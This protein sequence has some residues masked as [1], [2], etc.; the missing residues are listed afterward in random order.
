MSGARERLQ[1]AEDGSGRSGIG[2]LSASL[3]TPIAA[4]LAIAG[5]FC[6]ANKS[7]TVWSG[8]VP[9]V[10]LYLIAIVL[11]LAVLLSERRTGDGPSAPVGLPSHLK[12]GLEWGLLAGVIVVGLFLRIHAI[13][14]IP[15]GLNNDE[16]INAIEAT[17][18]V[19]GKPFSTVTERGLNRETMFHY[20]AAFSY[21]HPRI[22]LNLVRAMPAVFG[23]QSKLI[24]DPLIDRV[25]PLR[26]VSIA[27]AYSSYRFYQGHKVVKCCG[28][29]LA[30]R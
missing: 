28:C 9:G 14:V 22:A 27:T 17:E 7:G 26:A 16:A 25:F 29:L 8:V 23:L 4:L 12:P 30:R 5:Q 21:E 1:P 10:G 13:D 15:R 19:E 6:L 24:N 20:L 11:L 18:I 3:G 2:R